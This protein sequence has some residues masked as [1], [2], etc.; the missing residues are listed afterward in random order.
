VDIKQLTEDI[1]KQVNIVDIIS[2]YTQVQKAGRNY[3]CLC[4]FHDDKKLGNFYIN[5]DKQIFKCFSCG[6]GGNA[7]TFVQYRENISFIE[8]LRKVCDLSGIK[9]DRLTSNVKRV[10]IPTEIKNI[11]DCLSN[12]NSFYMTSLYQNINGRKALE[13]LTQRGLTEEI[14]K[15]FNI[16]Y[17]QSDGKNVVKYL[18]DKNY[19]LKTIAETGIVRIDETPLKDLNAG[20][21]TFGITNKDNKIVGFSARIFGDIKSDAKYINTKETKLFN[22]S[23]ILY[24]YYSALN[25]SRRVGYVYVL[26]GFMDVIACYRVG[27]KSAVGL[28][29]TAFT[30][31]QL[32][33][34]RF[35]RCEI[36]LCL[37]LDTPGQD[38][39]SK[40]IEVLDEKGIKYR[41]VNNNSGFHGKD[42]DEILKNDGEKG[43]LSFLDNLISK[44]E[45]L[46]NY[47][48]KSFDL[49]S[50]DG[51]KKM[52]KAFIPVISQTNS[53]LD[54]E[55][56]INRISKLTNFSI[57]TILD[58]VNNM[59]T[60]IEKN[61]NEDFA[62]WYNSNKFE[63]KKLDRLQFA[64][65]QMMRYILE[66]KE[67]YDQY[68]EKLGYFTNKD[69]RQII[70]A[71]DEY[72]N[73]DVINQ[74]NYSLT[75]IITSLTSNENLEQKT[76]E[77]II[78]D[79]TTV[80]LDKSRYCPPYNEKSFVNLVETINNE[81]ELKRSKEAYEN[82]IINLNPEEKNKQTVNF[83]E[84]I[85]ENLERD[86]IKK[87]GK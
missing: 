77:K 10:E 70:D 63:S 16:G 25:E 2:H 7:I 41:L 9:D 67:A 28:M 83:L 80:A 44:G 55:D 74:S 76:K 64:E 81:R 33:M 84:S 3:T 26:E 13:Y 50:L 75:N 52:L 57:K 49:S 36:R 37:D 22:K 69:Y 51:R 43:L 86:K 38:N 73:T 62:K 39:M 11:Y 27:I 46:I 85:K 24:N 29:G 56:Y 31:Q 59:Q 58:M 87:G 40:I 4:P 79:I 6:K 23:D 82:S 60:N 35:M 32:Q 65:R 61:D 20:R 72:V 15:N 30:K 12:I 71:I 5:P 47:Y 45:W 48:A 53:R 17:S 21:I 66:N 19:S 8:A 68:T 78:D 14:I 18:N 34:L 42:S 1:L 54:R